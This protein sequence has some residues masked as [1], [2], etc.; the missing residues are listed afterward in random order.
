[1][2][3]YTTIIEPYLGAWIAFGAIAVVILIGVIVL[4]I[5]G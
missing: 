4:W 5:W 1:M 3:L 2:N